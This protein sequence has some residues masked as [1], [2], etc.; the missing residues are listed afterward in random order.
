MGSERSMDNSAAAIGEMQASVEQ[1]ASWAN[2][3]SWI[4]RVTLCERYVL[5]ELINSCADLSA[6]H[7]RQQKMKLPT[8][9]R[10][11]GKKLR[12]NRPSEKGKI[13]HPVH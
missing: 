6:S 7:T 10:R 11:I 5:D 13:K 1:L 2:T 9:T 4:K 3:F 12:A 8:N